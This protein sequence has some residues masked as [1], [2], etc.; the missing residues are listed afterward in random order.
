MSG[1]MIAIIVLGV[2]GIGKLHLT[3]NP[4][5]SIEKLMHVK[6]IN[7]FQNCCG[8]ECFFQAAL[9]APQALLS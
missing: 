3:L 1:A 2:I 9:L 8:L 5:C 7:P 6:P 4:L